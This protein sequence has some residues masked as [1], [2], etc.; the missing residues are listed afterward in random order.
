MGGRLVDLTHIT[1]EGSRRKKRKNRR[2]TERKRVHQERV[3]ISEKKKKEKIDIL[4]K[5]STSNKSIR[6]KVFFVLYN[7]AFF[8]LREGSRRRKRKNQTRERKRVH[9]ERVF[10]LE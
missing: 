1:S 10:I 8:D 2:F 5:K 6:F 3:L 4:E 7:S 9:Q